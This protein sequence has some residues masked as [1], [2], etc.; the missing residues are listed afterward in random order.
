MSPDVIWRAAGRTSWRCLQVEEGAAHMQRDEAAATARTSDRQPLSRMHT[1]TQ[2]R[3][4]SK[5]LCD[6]CSL[7]AIT[8]LD[9][10]VSPSA[11]VI[12]RDFQ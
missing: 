7:T 3:S 5:T 10:R 1:A 9:S 2:G 8:R 12:A 6:V 11:V 4:F